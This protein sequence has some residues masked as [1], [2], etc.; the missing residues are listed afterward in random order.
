[1]VII[2]K[3]GGREYTEYLPKIANYRPE[4]TKENSRD[5]QV[6]S[7]VAY[8]ILILYGILEQHNQDGKY[9]ANMSRMLNTLFSCL[10]RGRF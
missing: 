7:A 5:D 8:R 1:M 2:L 10:D 9:D 4:T 3:N 6:S